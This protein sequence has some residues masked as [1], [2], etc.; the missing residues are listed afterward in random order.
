VPLEQSYTILPFRF[1]RINPQKVFLT[2][3]VGEFLFL[4]S[5]IFN[6]FVSYSL[7]T[8]TKEFFDLKSK[9]VVADKDIEFII[10]ALAVKYR[11]KKKFLNDFTSLHMV[12]P[13]IRCNSRCI[14]CQ[15]SS[16][17]SDDKKYDMDK[18]TAKKIVETIFMSPSRKI[19]IEFQGGEPLLN[20]EIVK[21]II[22]YAE[23]L[24]VLYK[25]SVD[26]V[27]CTNL[28]LINENILYFF[29]RHN[30]ILST[31]L[32]GPK[33]LQNKNR[34]LKNA[35]NSYD[36]FITKLQIAKNIIGIE[37][38][39]A[40][41]TATRDS[42]SQFPA[43]IDEYVNS[44][45]NCI[46]L[47]MINP[48]GLARKDNL[49]FQY[50]VEEFIKAYQKGLEYII[51]LNLRGKFFVEEFACLL[52]TRI[53][54]PFA[55]GFVDLQSPAGTGIESVIYNY[56]GDVY[57]SD[58]GRMLG[59]MGDKKFLMGNIH[60][61]S[62]EELFNSEFLRS[63]ISNSCLETLPCCHSCAY[64]PFCGAD[65]VRNYVEQNDIIG[66]KMK[67]KMCRKNKLI[68]QYLLKLIEENNED[69]MDVFWSWVTRR[70]LDEVRVR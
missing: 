52:L 31:S 34:P 39:S 19:K 65:S 29:K 28:T 69:I 11:T 56:N 30:V 5:D 4:P 50:S 24:N 44:G 43:I 36:I 55:T 35:P 46:F 3:E 47:R 61:H 2:N 59:E 37:R 66:N 64:L 57:V 20:L 22:K 10:E 67:S 58:E 32:D 54:T 49:N 25:K 15:V 13:T 42:L 12:I 41:M 38:I 6:K 62:Y 51:D 18:C 17:P 40:L 16:K 7:D 68:M 9:H 14:Y 60:T 70:S 23:R 1:E 48:Y 27:V 63:I 21:Y 26:F 8:H 45:F 53:L 33:E